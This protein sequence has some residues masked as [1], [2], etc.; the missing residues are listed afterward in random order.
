MKFALTL[1]PLL[2]TLLLATAPPAAA[3]P[4]KCAPSSGRSLQLIYAGSLTPVFK[5]LSELYGCRSGVRISATPTGAID[6]MRRMATENKPYD[7]YAT[8][9]YTNI[10]QFLEPMGMARFNLVFAAGRMVLA[11][12]AKN[13]KA[14]G[15]ADPAG[16]SSAPPG[17]VTQAAG[18]WY[19]ILAQP[20]VVIAA[21]H[22]YLDPGGYKAHM[23]FQLAERYYHAPGLAGRLMRNVLVVP[24]EAARTGSPKY[25][26]D[27]HLMYEHRA[28]AAASADS[29][30]RYLALPSAVAMD[31]FALNSVYARAA[32]VVPGL[33]VA[34]A[35]EQIAVH[36]ARVA[37]SLTIPANAANKEDA[38]AFVQLLLSLEGQEAMR[39]AGLQPLAP[40]LVAPDDLPS[41]PESLRPLVTPSR[42]AFAGWR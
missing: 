1:W 10:T 16:A 4:E 28:A 38:L 29:D 27:F 34:A 12:S 23:V 42:E 14:R 9:D 26:S 31:D 37:W 7:L 8:A 32:I 5:P 2:A 24:L 6:G 41:V 36:G 22:P 17:T 21:T 33:G 20:G 30:F 35:P 18:N 19:E 25:A 13:L 39:K 15:I 11:Y 40:A 3:Q